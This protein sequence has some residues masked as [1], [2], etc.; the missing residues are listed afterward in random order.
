MRKEASTPEGVYSAGD[1][2]GAQ[3]LESMEREIDR[4]AEQIEVGGRRYV[5]YG[6][7]FRVFAVAMVVMVAVE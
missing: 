7:G 6:S 1:I 4:A 5:C 2:A 3:E